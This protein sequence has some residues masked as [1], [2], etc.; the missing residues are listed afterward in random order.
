MALSI[1]SCAKVLGDVQIS[2]GVQ[3]GLNKIIFIRRSRLNIPS[4]VI[5]FV[6]E[7]YL[8]VQPYT[9][10]GALVS[11]LNIV[12]SHIHISLYQDQDS[13]RRTIRRAPGTN[14]G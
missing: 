10:G 7:E 11:I 3:S 8:K 1:V 9:S 13:C 4:P 12:R 14:P 2:D 5:R 6:D